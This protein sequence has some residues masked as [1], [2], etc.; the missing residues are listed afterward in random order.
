ME[1]HPADVGKGEG[2]R[3]RPCVVVAA[4]GEQHG[5]RRLQNRPRASSDASGAAKNQAVGPRLDRFHF[6]LAGG[7]IRIAEARRDRQPN[8]V[9]LELLGDL[10]HDIHAAVQIGIGPAEGRARHHVVAGEASPGRLP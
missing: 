8:R 10:L 6:E 1:R 5:L 3:I 4:G 2:A 9:L 7:L